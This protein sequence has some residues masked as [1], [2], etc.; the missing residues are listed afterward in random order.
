[1]GHA[2]VVAACMSLLSGCGNSAPAETAP[3]TDSAPRVEQPVDLTQYAGEKKCSLLPKEALSKIGVGG[4]V[5]VNDFGICMWDGGTVGLSV[6]PRN[7]LS[8]TY[9]LRAKGK[10]GKFNPG[11]I[12]GYPVVATS[13]SRSKQTF[14]SVVVGVSDTASFSVSVGDV[15]SFEDA[16]AAGKDLAAAAIGKLKAG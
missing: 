9:E 15:G 6:N 13:G 10:F 4:S 3:T 8:R 12:K 14:C 16:C 2:L 5:T 1:M 7:G 11:S